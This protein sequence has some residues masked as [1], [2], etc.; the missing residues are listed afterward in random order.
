[1]PGVIVVGAGPGI[2]LAV[3]RRFA[4]EGLPVGLIARSDATLV[5]VGGELV[6]AGAETA[7]ETADVRDEVA[8]RGALARLV[9]RFGVPEVLVYNAAVIQMDRFG[10]LTAQ[11]HLDAWA[12]NVV[13]AISAIGHVGPQMAARG[14]GTIVVTGGMPTPIPEV[15]S[16]SLGKA[17]VRAL[18]ELVA[19][20]LEPAG[21]HVATV[22][23]GG[24][25][26]P[27]TAFD[28]EEIAEQ[29]WLLHTQS[30]ET[31]EREILYTGT[32]LVGDPA[33]GRT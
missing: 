14:T 18:V 12:T 29:Y 23:V 3:A 15:T 25:V 16:L 9:G 27:G 24:A 17:G 8:L 5:S 33:D 6:A 1:M 26:A 20:E 11:E 32:A 4:T 30:R 21:V 10:E 28:P 19:T 2:G 31:W 22:T 7:W 13:G